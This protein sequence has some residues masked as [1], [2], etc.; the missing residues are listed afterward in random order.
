ML[1]SDNTPMLELV[2]PPALHLRL[3][4][5]NKLYDELLKLFPRL[6]DW[7]KQLH[8]IREDYH[9]S[10][11]EGNQ[12]NILLKNLDILLQMI[13]N[14][15][16][17]FYNCFVAFHDVIVTCF[18]YVL[19]PTYVTKIHAFEESYRTLNISCT[20]KVHILLTHVTE[21]IKNIANRPLGLY[22]EQVVEAWHAKFERIYRRYRIK[23]ISSPRYLCRLYQAI[24]D[25]NSHQIKKY[26][27]CSV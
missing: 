11:F 8:I 1:N 6:N 9:G 10:S 14:S 17:Q 5:V 24:M 27:A 16:I 19:D 18:S 22:S 21:Y 4:I 3:G 23:S 20:S 2:P 26:S 13:P 12:C 15:L 7:P 25:F